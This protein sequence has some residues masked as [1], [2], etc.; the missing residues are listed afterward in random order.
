MTRPQAVLQ[1][2]WETARCDTLIMYVHNDGAHLMLT[3]SIQQFGDTIIGR[4]YLRGVSPDIHFIGDSVL[5][6]LVADTIALKNVD[7]TCCVGRFHGTG[8]SQFL[9]TLILTTIAVS[10][11][12]LIAKPRFDV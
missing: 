5:T 6:T 7:S 8:F 12:L 11:W 10:L 2:G 3:T 1:S 4:R 9:G